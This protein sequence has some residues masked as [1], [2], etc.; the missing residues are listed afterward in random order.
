LV[1]PTVWSL[2]FAKTEKL[3]RKSAFL[4]FHSPCFDGIISAVV[5]SDFLEIQYRWVFER[6]CAVDYSQ[7]D[8][9]LSRSLGKR[10]AVVDFI[11]HPQATFWADHHPT[12]FLSGDAKCDFVRRRRGRNLFYNDRLG[13]CS[14]LLWQ[15]LNDGFRYRNEAYS[16]MV[17]WADR[18]DS[19]RY[20]S[21]AEAVLGENPALR[22]RASLGV[23]EEPGFYEGLVKALRSKTLDE[24]ASLPQVDI[25]AKHVRS[26]TEAGLERLKN[27]IWVDDN[28]IAVFD[29]D[30][31][32]VAISRYAPYLF[33]PEARYSAGIVR[34]NHGTKITAMRNPWRDF[35]S[36]KLGKIFERFGGGGHERVGSVLVPDTLDA[37]T[38]LHKIV[39]QIRCEDVAPQLEES[40]A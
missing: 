16:D 14:K 12:T 6:F 24:V 30:S 10:C 3:M 17:E 28:G 33:F 32:G 37:R 31:R 9:W 23:N 21:V 26:Q 29:V 1:N 4:Y 36:V 27:S 5:A 7:R 22:I 34:S 38:T 39:E 40:R 20:S 18:I 25:R 8:I 11:Y 15:S 19:A 13:S 35:P 2:T